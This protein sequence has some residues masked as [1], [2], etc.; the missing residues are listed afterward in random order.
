MPCFAI[1]N[2]NRVKIK[3][4]ICQE[5]HLVFGRAHVIA[6]GGGPDNIIGWAGVTA[7]LAQMPSAWWVL[8]GPWEGVGG[9]RKG[10]AP[11]TQLDGQ[12]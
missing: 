7:L 5:V 10:G 11:R 4:R 2:E 8:R 12:G 1:K 9:C 3:S 6:A